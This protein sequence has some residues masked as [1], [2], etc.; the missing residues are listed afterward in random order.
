MA[1]VRILVDGYSLLHHWKDLAPGKARHSDAA[2]EELI[3]Q[4]T[5]YSD[6]AGTPVTIVF[7]G[8]GPTRGVDPAPANPEVE[9]IYTRAG[10]SADQ[11]IP[12]LGSPSYQEREEATA[13]LIEIGAPAFAK[14]RAAYHATANLEV[15]LR[16][17]HGQQHRQ[18]RKRC[19]SR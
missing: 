14:L 12:K 6:A 3:H 1:V 8:A 16:I 17:E 2:R 7:D 10:Q 11:L 15:L 18:C 4:L 5:R 9:V 19:K 13:G